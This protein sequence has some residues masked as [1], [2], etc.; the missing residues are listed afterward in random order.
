MET[1]ENELTLVSEIPYLAA[2]WARQT[3][4]GRTASGVR[5]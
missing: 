2:A 5:I 4:S 3:G 1:F